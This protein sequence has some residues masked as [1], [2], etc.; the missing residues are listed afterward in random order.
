ME[1]DDFINMKIMVETPIEAVSKLGCSILVSKSS[2]SSEPTASAS[3][4]LHYKEHELTVNAGR[5]GSHV[6]FELTTP[7]EEFR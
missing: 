3:L 4:E 6:T 7:L 1:S 2:Q 5:Q